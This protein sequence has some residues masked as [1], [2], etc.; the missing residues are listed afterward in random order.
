VT[1]VQTC[2]LPISIL[3]SDGDGK[4]HA[5]DFFH[6]FDERLKDKDTRWIRRWFDLARDYGSEVIVKV[7]PD[8]I[9]YR[10]FRKPFPDALF[11]GALANCTTPGKEKA[12][13]HGGAQFM[14]R[15]FI[16]AVYSQLCA[17]D[18]S[19]DGFKYKGGLVCADMVLAHL[20]RKNGIPL[21][22]Y[23]EVT[24]HGYFRDRKFAI[25][26]GRRAVITRA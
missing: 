19:G 20:A 11:F 10:E 5:C 3:I 14:T 12:Y 2:A 6:K 13:I 22:N 17:G 8:S 24:G 25:S 4:D 7:D 26:H 21:V 16:D 1:G 15:A 18:F 23:E 9:L